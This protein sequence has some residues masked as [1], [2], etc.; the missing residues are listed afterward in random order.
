MDA[1]RR[2]GDPGID[3][4]TDL[5][6]ETAAAVEALARR[7]RTRDAAVHAADDDL[8]DAELFAREFMLALRGRGWRPTEA[9]RMP[10]WKPGPRGSGGLPKSEEAAEL[11][12]KARADAEAASAAYQASCRDD[13]GDAA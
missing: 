1:A 10:A 4:G 6:R 13:P 9:R 12:R 2:A 7:I 8:A 5:D 3:P 11:V